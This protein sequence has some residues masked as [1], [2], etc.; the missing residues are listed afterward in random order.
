MADRLA[1]RQEI[2]VPAAGGEDREGVVVLVPRLPASLAPWHHLDRLADHL[3]RDLVF[4]GLVVRDPSAAPWAR[5]GIADAC[6]GMG[7]S[8]RSENAGEPAG[9]GS[10]TGGDG[11]GAGPATE[12]GGGA[13][14]TA[15]AVPEAGRDAGEGAGSA[16]SGEARDGAGKAVPLASSAEAPRQSGPV[17]GLPGIL[18]I[19]C[20]LPADLRFHDGAP[21]RPEDVVASVGALV[22]PRA[23]RLRDDLVLRHLRGA[24]AVP[25]PPPDV[26][27]GMWVGTARPER[28]GRWVRIDFVVADPLAFERL[29]SVAVLPARDVRRTARPRVGAGPFRLRSMSPDR[30]ELVR[31]VPERG[32]PSVVVVRAVPDGADRLRLLRRRKAHVVWPVAPHHVPEELRRTGTGARFRGYL[33]V[34]PVYDV[35]AMRVDRPPLRDVRV[36]RAVDALLPRAAVAEARAS[37]VVPVRPPALDEPASELDLAAIEAAGPEFR[38]ARYGLPLP[39]DPAEDAAGRSL[40]LERLAEVG[41]AP[42]P[43]GTLR[44]DGEPLRLVLLYAH[45]EG[46]RRHARL[47]EGALEE[48]GLLVGHASA[49][50]GYLRA[51]PLAQGAFDLALLRMSFVRTKDPTPYFH[52]RGNLN[53]FG[54]A[55]AKV[56]GILEAFRT[57]RTAGERRRALE[58]LAARLADLV[59]FGVLAVPA[60]VL[61]VDRSLAEPRISDGVLDLGSLRWADP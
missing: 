42:D 2:P 45:D 49:A 1:R 8:R 44:R 28:D 20:H 56:D 58:D 41:Y 48:A 47:V 55:D 52:S 30:I 13:A 24:E 18:R 16:G 22:D 10:G 29:A 57:A 23:A 4:R 37:L 9:E 32:A 15:G 33:S 50:F 14:G 19:Y 11:S 61:L 39:P 54:L 3:A 38:P 46:A 7:A 5:P 35:A 6:V 25:G 43:K 31:T 59:P 51:G 21:V 27:G 40:A 34:L 60:E 12:G 36:R 26:A 17:G 53:V